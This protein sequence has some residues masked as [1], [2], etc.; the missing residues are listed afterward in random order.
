MQRV[1]GPHRWRIIGWIVAASVVAACG[2]KS[3][4]SIP[5]ATSGGTGG[6]VSGDAS[7]SAAADTGAG[8]GSFGT[9]TSGSSDP[10][11]SG[12]GLTGQGTAA[13]AGGPS[14]PSGAAAPATGTSGSATATTARPG[15]TAPTAPRSVP[16][17]TPG[18][19][20]PAAAT[21]AGD[22]TG[23][24]ATE[25]VIGVHGPITGA[26]PIPEDSVNKAVNLYWKYMAEKGGIF[27]RNVRVVFRDDQYNPS[28]ALQVCREMVEQEKAFLL[29]GIGADQVA[30]CARYASQVGVPY[31]SAGAG[32]DALLPYKTYFALSM[33][34]P[35]Q[36]PMVARMVKQA[37]KARIGVLVMNTPNY[38]DSYVAMQA[39]AK[40]E[41]LQ[42]VRAARIGKQPSQSETLAEANAMRTAGAESVLLFVSPLTFVNLAHSAQSQA[43]NPLWAGPGLQGGLNLVAEFGCPSI[44]AARFLSPFPQLDVIDKYDADYKPTYRKYNGE[45]ADDLGLI[46]WGLSKTIGLILSAN[47]QDLT[48]QSFLAT[49][50]SG[51]EFVSNVL[52]PS[53]FSATN[54]FGANQAHILEADC[55]NRR[56]KTIAAFVSS[57]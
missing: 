31:L 19:T 12:S 24:S 38:D 27:G 56:Y 45:E 22:R 4:L 47:G 32:R 15:A 34:Y 28:H 50:S 13:T 51:R 44:G 9:G 54:H 41:G 17:A 52:P 21:T 49:I 8:D 2:Q 14:R 33:D 10:G 57:L 16:G 1:A 26:A 23:V 29:V 36:A 53:R 30:P 42:V 46:M 25:I 35:S 39:A 20:A 48:R 11:P 5:S 43:Y 40:N 18:T 55:A 37:G 6:T 3:G 7:S